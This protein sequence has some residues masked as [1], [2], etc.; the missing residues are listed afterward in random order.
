MALNNRKTSDRPLRASQKSD[1]SLSAISRMVLHLIRTELMSDISRPARADSDVILFLFHHF[2][3]EHHDGIRI[4]AAE[5][6]G[7]FGLAG[8]LASIPEDI[9]IGKGAVHGHGANLAPVFIEIEDFPYMVAPVAAHYPSPVRHCDPDLRSA[10]FHGCPVIPRS[11]G[12]P[13]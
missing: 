4:A 13:S 10:P 5:L 9:D 2:C 7:A 6:G 1:V 11:A 3:L 8:N 12:A